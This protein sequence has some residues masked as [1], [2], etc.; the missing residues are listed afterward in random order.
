[1]DRLR[2]GTMKGMWYAQ[3]PARRSAQMATDVAVLV[4]CAL[5]VVAGRAVYAAVA[6]MAAPARELQ[7]AGTSLSGNV[8]NAQ[9]ALADIP[10]V[11][12]RVSG[13]FGDLAGTGT[14]MTS[15]GLQLENTVHQLAVVLGWSTVLA[16]VLVAVVP[17][18][19]LRL[20]FA[21]RAEAA[22]RFIDSDA[23]LDLF[24]LRA[25]SRQPM[26]RLAAISDDPSG[27]WRDGHPEVVRRLAEL[28]LRACGLRPP[29]RHESRPGLEPPRA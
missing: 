15:A 6:A 22:Q 10:L 11:G 29:A 27:A 7:Q 25:L 4:W 19:V 12:E 9:A 24:A 2:P 17:W 8:R 18:L 3:L 28:E 1:M 13:A 23:D 26:H 14:T 20:R 21:R 5:W 16:P